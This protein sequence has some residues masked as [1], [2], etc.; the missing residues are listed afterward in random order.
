VS[1]Y[2]NGKVK[3]KIYFPD[4]K[5]SLANKETYIEEY[6]QNGKIR[7][8]GFM[9]DNQKNGL[10]ESFYE[11]GEAHFIK[12]FEN[13][14]ENGFRQTFSKNGSWTM[15]KISEGILNGKTTAWNYDSLTSAF[16]LVT[17]EYLNGRKDGMWTYKDTAKHKL[18]EI[19]YSNGTK[20]GVYYQFHSNEI[21][22]IK[23]YYKNDVLNDTVTV[24]DN[25]GNI[26]S[27]VVY[28]NGNQIQE[29]KMR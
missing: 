24:Y 27:I 21:V 25:Q 22:S 3:E 23:G 13:G 12:N 10:W 7:Q 17:G 5:D 9:L 20:N 18:M 16:Q 28:D 6:Y 4:G 29:E 19:T 15:S 26:V 8:S 11:D 1:S 14:I 2:P